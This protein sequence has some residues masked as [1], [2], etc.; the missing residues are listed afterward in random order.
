MVHSFNLDPQKERE[1]I[2]ILQREFPLTSRP[3]EEIARRLNLEEGLL[4]DILK[5]WQKEGKLRQISAIFNP[6]S[7]GHSSSLFAF[8]VPSQN[9]ER[10][11]EVI[12]GHPGVSHNYLRDHSYNLWFTLVV[13]PGRDLLEEAKK[14]YELSGAEDLLYLPVIR[15][16]K[17]AVTFEMENGEA[18]LE[19][20]QE[21]RSK[22]QEKVFSEKDIKILRALQEPLPLVREPFKLLADSL[23]IAEEAIFF[24]LKEMERSGCLRR[25]GALFKHQKLGFREN[26]MVA[27]VVPESR[28][29]EVG[30]SLSKK[31]FIT[32]CYLRK[33]YPHWPYNIY[34]MCHFRG[35]GL[36]SI[37]A[38]S[39]EINIPYYLPLKTV[40]EFKKIRLKLFYW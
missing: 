12:N 1:L 10:A 21:S 18:G 24:W 39:E 6:Q 30:K 9:L 13:P 37:K 4:L 40:K 19:G 2:R 31:S 35:D 8:K 23:G 34:T 28:I 36:E 26:F 3:F 20:Q 5:D 29:E 16:F 22:T 11:V 38:L 33:S 27:W 14:L 7:L 32:H 17:I 15:V 25:F